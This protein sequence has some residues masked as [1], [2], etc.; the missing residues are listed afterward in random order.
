MVSEQI[1]SKKF[2]LSNSDKCYILIP[3][4]PNLLFNFHKEKLCNRKYLKIKT[5]IYLNHIYIYSMINI[6]I[7]E[8]LKKRQKKS[9]WITI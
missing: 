8:Y 4:H 1:N 5:T 2:N 3:L 7:I 9:P 6:Y